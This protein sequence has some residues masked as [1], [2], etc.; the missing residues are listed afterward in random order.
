MKIAGRISPC[1]PKC[2]ALARHPAAQSNAKLKINAF[3]TWNWNKSQT[4]PEGAGAKPGGASCPAFFSIGVK[5]SEH[6]PS[7]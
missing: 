2:F 1:F 7:G 6:H 5:P 3:S 4:W